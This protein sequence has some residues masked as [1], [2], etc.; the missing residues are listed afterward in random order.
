MFHTE[1]DRVV[2]PSTDN[3]Y[4]SPPSL[5]VPPQDTPQ[6]R[7]YWDHYVDASIPWY[8]RALAGAV[9]PVAGILSLGGCGYLDI[10]E[11]EDSCGDNDGDGHD[12]LACGG[13]DC[14][15]GNS[16]IFPGARE[17]CNGVDENCND[18][19]DE[20]VMNIFH[21]DQDG[22][23]FG[24]V[25]ETTEACEQPEGYVDNSEDCDDSE[26]EINP[27]ASEQCNEIDD[28]CDG[29]VDEG[30][31]TDTYYQD[32]D[33]DGYGN[34]AV[35]QMA[36]EA[37][38]GYVN[39]NEDCDDTDPSIYPGAPEI[40]DDGIDQDCS[41][42]VGDDFDTIQEGI[43]AVEDGGT[44]TVC[45]GT[46]REHLTIDKSVNIVG[47]GDVIL[48]GNDEASNLVYAEGGY[49]ISF[50]N[51]N[52][53][54][55]GAILIRGPTNVNFS[56]CSFY[57]NTLISY[58]Y[59]DIGLYQGF[60]VLGVFETDDGNPTLTISNSDF[61]DN[62]CNVSDDDIAWSSMCVITTGSAYFE[63]VSFENNTADSAVVGTT[64]DL[65]IDDSH[66]SS[67]T[68]SDFGE[69]TG[70][71]F[72]NDGAQVSINNSVFTDNW[73]ESASAVFLSHSIV[74][75]DNCTVENNISEYPFYGA[76]FM[77]A[78]TDTEFYSVNTTW[79]GNNP[80]DV[81]IEYESSFYDYTAGSTT[82]FSCTGV[83]GSCY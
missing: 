7:I 57:G 76:V 28:N 13:D 53:T 55:G 78:H 71:L 35:M 46:Y 19:I 16:A 51:I 4:F 75:L 58:S 69:M 5:T 22:D 27:N 79:N 54:R 17:M 43:D 68:V 62:E 1:L 81:S 66:F 42:C 59:A 37:P 8:E 12:D 77:Y 33:G 30:V 21:E 72:A 26:A 18:Q 49:S 63:N 47:D 56:N 44:V 60:T 2:S 3:S 41:G 82:D 50:D 36:C 52:F 70:L 10:V 38:E 74:T 34:T 9:L 6:Q 32:A 24:N 73:G 15:D 23:S 11:Y 65:T 29:E 67:N 64:S 80:Y 31:Q 48:D 14:N 39:N 40:A 25:G 20:G 45:P 83:P 61:F